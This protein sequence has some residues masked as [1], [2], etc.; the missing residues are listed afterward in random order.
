MG[1]FII[2]PRY[3]NVQSLGLASRSLSSGKRGAQ[4]QQVQ[5]LRS[6]DPMESET[7]TLIKDHQGKVLRGSEKATPITG[8]RIV[9]MPDEQ[10]ERL[11]RERMDLVVLRD[12]PI[13]LI[14]PQRATSVHKAKLTVKDL[15]HLQA[16]GLQAARKK[17]F[18]GTGEG[19]VVAVLDTGVDGTH[20]ELTNRVASAM[21]FDVKTWQAKPQQP[22]QD[23][24]GHG[25]HVAGLICGKTVG[26]APGARVFSGVMIPRRHGNLSDFIL[27]LEWS[28]QQPEVQ[29]VNM[30]AGIPDWVEGMQAVIADL[31]IAGVLPIIAAGNEG[32]NRTRSPG[33]YAEVLSIGAANA[34]NKVSSWSSGGFLTSNNHQY[35]V[36]ALV[37]PGEQVYSCVM[38]GGYEAWKGTSMATPIV[39]GIAALVLQ[40]YHDTDLT[41]TDL[42]EALLDSCQDLGAKPERQGA[43]LVQVTPAL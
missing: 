25:T 37:A 14:D 1:R 11:R 34:E 5:T 32:R 35:Y 22:S 43:G 33:N 2:R 20:P 17:R 23:T 40:K 6:Q 28:A 27:A 41:V 19:V 36:P 8:A 3:S 26:V 18:K 21:T 16:I 38:G 15:W 42:Q 4:I 24:D 39:S 12:Q 31:L 13:D 29:I 10:A 30:S 7:T 9:E